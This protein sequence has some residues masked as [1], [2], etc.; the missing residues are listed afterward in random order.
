[1]RILILAGLGFFGAMF[2]GHWLALEL[3]AWCLG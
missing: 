2:V 1:M 3:F